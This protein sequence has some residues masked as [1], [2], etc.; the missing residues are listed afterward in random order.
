MRLAR[1]WS[2]AAM[3]TFLKNLEGLLASAR[4]R[5]L[6][7]PPSS[8]ALL[9]LARE[10]ARGRGAALGIILLI[11]ANWQALPPWVKILGFLALFSA[12]HGSAIWIR[13]S[14]RPWEKTAE[15][16]HFMGAGLFLAGVG[17]IAQIYHLNARP[18]NGVL[19]WWVAE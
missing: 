8:E 13:L 10:S 12:C 1:I 9:A 19:L 5:G 2:E 4:D 17:L 6:I 16:L 14:G 15:A 3:A 7:D 11:S 18:P